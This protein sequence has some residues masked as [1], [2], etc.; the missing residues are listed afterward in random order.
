MDAYICAEI[1]DRRTRRE[2]NP[3]KSDQK[4]YCVYSCKDEHKAK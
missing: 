2:A 1:R 4:V 3:V